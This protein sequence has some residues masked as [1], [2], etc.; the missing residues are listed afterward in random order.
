MPIARVGSKREAELVVDALKRE[1]LDT[2]VVP[3]ELLMPDR[4]PVRLRG[5]DFDED[6]LGL[7]DFNTGNSMTLARNDLALIVSGVVA[8]SRT[9]QIE[10]KRRGKEPK[11]LERVE[12]GRDEAVL[13]IYDR[14]DPL[15][16]RIMLAGFDFSCLGEDKGYL[17]VENIRR[18]V[19]VLCEFAPNSNLVSDYRD[20]RREIG[21]VWPLDERQDPQ[22]LQRSGF[23]KFDFGKTVSSSNMRQLNRFSRLQW[24]LL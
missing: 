21:L 5:I 24:H 22:G 18:L 10:K 15:G 23:A 17:A 8:E 6:S 11:V 13:D 7:V 16:Y 4:P 12:T 20:V 3:D 1:G 9:D 2:L 19:T 14:L